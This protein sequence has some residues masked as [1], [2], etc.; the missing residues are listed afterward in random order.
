MIY[1]KPSETRSVLAALRS[2]VP[3]RVVSLCEAK[4]VAELQANKLLAL[5]EIAEGAVPNEIVTELP[6]VQVIYE[7]L[8]VS[9]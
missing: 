8:P 6:R 1:I 3:T 9:G 5:F 2:V 4:R 7:E